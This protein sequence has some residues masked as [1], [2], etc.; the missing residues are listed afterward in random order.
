MLKSY[1]DGCGNEIKS[2]DDTSLRVEYLLHRAAH[3]PYFK[4]PEQ[5][6]S[7]S[8]GQQYRAQRRAEASKK[9][10]GGHAGRIELDLGCDACAIPLRQISPREYVAAC[11]C[12]EN[13]QIVF[14]DFAEMKP[15][16]PQALEVRA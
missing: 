1:C 14:E 3:C 8:W 10:N 5:H 9:S 7:A 15:I 6:R 13:D 2:A 11:K 12:P 4:L 16:Y